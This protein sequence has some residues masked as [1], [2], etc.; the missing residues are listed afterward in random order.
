[1]ILIL[2]SIDDQATIDVIRWLCYLNSENVIRL[3][4]ADRLLIECIAVKE[5]GT[6]IIV[7]LLPD[8]KIIA[9]HKATSFWY[10]RGQWNFYVPK[11][12]APKLDAALRREIKS[13]EGFINNFFNRF[14]QRI[15]SYQE[16]FLSKLTCLL[17]ARSVGLK[18]PETL[19]TSHKHSLNKDLKASKAISDIMVTTEEGDIMGLGTILIDSEQLRK[20]PDFFFPTLFQRYISKAYELR[21]F[22][23][24]GKLW[25]M[26]IFSQNNEKTKIDF[27]NYDHE[28]PNRTVPYLLPTCIEDKL[29]LLMKQLKLTNGSIDMVVDH[30]GDFYFLEVNPIG[31][32]SQVSTPC[33]YYLEKEIATFLSTSFSNRAKT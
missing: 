16:N 19:I 8:D 14:S 24:H 5:D 1:M 33:N 25:S 31:Q 3:N 26:A 17:A 20:A 10:R 23:L 11:T 6:E 12:E 32:F 30:F 22:Y 2:S 15:G 27:R 29:L 9:L 21:I 13:V 4:D 28:K 7:R 18:I